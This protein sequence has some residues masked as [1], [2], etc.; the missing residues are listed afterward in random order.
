M[1]QLLVPILS[2]PTVQKVITVSS[3]QS[4][5][6]PTMTYSQSGGESVHERPVSAGTDVNFTQDG[7]VVTLTVHI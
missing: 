3:L 4:Y 2:E 7:P 6:R 5:Q 1:A